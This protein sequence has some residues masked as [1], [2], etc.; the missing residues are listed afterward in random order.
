[1]TQGALGFDR[2][3]ISALVEEPCQA[4]HRVEF[5]ESRGGRG[6]LQIDHTP[7]QIPNERAGQGVAIHLEAQGERR[8]RAEARSDAPELSTGDRLVQPQAAA[9]EILITE[10]VKAEDVSALGSI[11]TAF[12]WMFR[13][14]PGR[15]NSSPSWPSK[16]PGWRAGRKSD[17]DAAASSPRASAKPP[18]ASGIAQAPATAVA[19]RTG[20]S[21]VSTPD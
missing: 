5:Q 8:Y 21:M 4:H 3:Q 6:V 2:S 9:P 17:F 11:D 20:L 10:G 16:A 12:A 1:V 13:S 7:L 14:N 18:N 19:I 15:R